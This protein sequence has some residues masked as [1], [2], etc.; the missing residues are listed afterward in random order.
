M[1]KK[2]RIKNKSSYRP[3]PLIEPL[4]KLLNQKL[5]DQKNDKRLCGKS[6]KNMYVLMK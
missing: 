2:D 1:K 6:Y 4:E 5:K 3:L